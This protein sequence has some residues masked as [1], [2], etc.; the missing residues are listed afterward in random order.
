M[1][2][3]SLPTLNGACLAIKSSLTAF[4]VKIS[5]RNVV[6]CNCVT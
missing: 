2:L 6:M 3:T 5:E 4:S 1:I